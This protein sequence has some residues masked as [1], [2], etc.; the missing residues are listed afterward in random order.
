MGEVID[1][2]ERLYER[3]ARQVDT[4]YPTV[5]SAL[6]AA[7][8]ADSIEERRR[9]S[10]RC[11]TGNFVSSELES[12]VSCINEYYRF[13][14]KQV[15]ALI[16]LCEASMVASIDDEAFHVDEK[17]YQIDAEEYYG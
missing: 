1:F 8:Q 6:H 15:I 16:E 2:E 9:D 17:Q 11:D 3:Q 7:I 5:V 4:V 14:P 13:T 12:A 10:L